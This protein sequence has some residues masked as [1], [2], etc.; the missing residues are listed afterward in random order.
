MSVPIEVPPG[1]GAM[2]PSLALTYNS[3]VRQ[4]AFGYGWD[5][6]LGKIQRCL[7]RGVPSCHDPTYRNDFVLELPT[8]TVECKLA[9]GG[10]CHALVEESFLR[11][12]YRP[13]ENAWQVLDRDGNRYTFG[14]EPARTGRTSGRSSSRRFHL[15]RRSPTYR[16]N[17]RSR[18]R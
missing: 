11:I 1:R 2:T 3:N 7:K 10:R 6:P 18:G 4:T 12:E 8:G 13:A 14:G 15:H 17:T 5:L 9:T 16:V